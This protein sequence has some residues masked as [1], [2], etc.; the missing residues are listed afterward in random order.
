MHA[1][2]ALRAPR[3][4]ATF[5]TVTLGL[6]MLA[7]V[8]SL[9]LTLVAP[10]LPDPDSPQADATLVAILASSALALLGVAVLT[11]IAF[12]VWMHAAV[13][14][15]RRIA[16]P[17]ARVPHPAWAVGSFFVPFANLWVPVAALRRSFEAT[18]AAL[19][20][21][22]ATMSPGFIAVWWGAW[23]LA[24][25][26]SKA[27]FKATINGVPTPQAQDLG[28]LLSLGGD[29]LT[30][31]AG[32]LCINVVRTITAMQREVA[33]SGGPAPAAALRPEPL[34]PAAHAADAGA[35]FRRAG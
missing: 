28:T 33:G 4:S 15:A 29:I 14:F 27:D 32:A 20:A 3:A 35:L 8:V 31:V 22:A 24:N 21:R 17:E 1:E 34:T 30:L 11:I 19:P 12:C 9:A 2:Q 25:L 5:A 26:V 16:P 7:S 10:A 18:R 23:L 6:S 13:A